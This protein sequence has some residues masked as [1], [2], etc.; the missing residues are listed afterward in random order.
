MT[1]YCSNCGKGNDDNSTFC[2]NCGERLSGMHSINSD[3]KSVKKG[4]NKVLIGVIVLLLMVIA[5]VGTYAFFYY[6]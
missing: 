1:K 6:Q 2:R 4:N 5:I 3:N